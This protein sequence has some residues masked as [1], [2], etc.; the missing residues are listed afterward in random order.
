VK[1]TVV[2]S[3]LGCVTPHGNDPSQV[4]AQLVAGQSAISTLHLNGLEPD[5]PAASA[6]FDPSPWFTRLQLAGVDR[7]SQMAVAA[8]QGAV[9]QAG[10]TTFPEASGVYF[11]SGMGGATAVDEAFRSFQATGR[12]HPLTVPAT[13]ANAGAAH[14][15]MRHKIYGPVLTY[16]VA[17]SS[18]AAAIAQAYQAIASGQIECAI[19]GGS[20][21]LLVPS[22]LRAWLAL[23]TLAPAGNQPALA[24]MPFSQE[25]SGLVLGEGAAFFVLESLEHA[26]ARGAN[27]LAV[28]AGFGISNDATHLTKPDASG[29]V[30]ALKQALANCSLDMADIGYCNAHGTATKI[31]DPV[32][33]EALARVWGDAIGDLQVSSTKALHGHL[34]GGAGALEA[35]V[36]VQAL[37][38]QQIPGQFHCS[39]QDPV[40]SVRLATPKSPAAPLHAA[41][42]NS[43][44]FGGTN[45]VLAFTRTR[46]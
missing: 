27:V 8:A 37:V 45:V 24:C 23:Q 34:L 28:L 3:G 19:A 16:S 25:R 40:C 10:L 9:T 7:V 41:I 29:Q 14:V 4:F 42:S 39:S 2:V 12:I 13:M 30:R 36:T 1:H 5:V 32:E 20:E 33:C 15:A 11:G 26:T 17:C 46:H 6:S 22:S 44:A 31:G 18:S 35:L 38:H 43:F 21:A